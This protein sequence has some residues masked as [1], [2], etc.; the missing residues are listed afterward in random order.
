MLLPGAAM[1]H[2]VFFFILMFHRF[3]FFIILG[4]PA[5]RREYQSMVS[6]AAEFG[7]KLAI[8]AF[9]SGE[10]GNQVTR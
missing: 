7:D 2:A 6:L 3:Y 10:F 4:C 9:P 1:E 8:L 5:T